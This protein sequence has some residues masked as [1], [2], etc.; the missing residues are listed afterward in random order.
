MKYEFN[1]NELLSLFK[2]SNNLLIIMTVDY[3]D[4][5]IRIIKVFIVFS[6]NAA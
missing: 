5:Q 6:Q 4:L 3:K 1:K 2:R